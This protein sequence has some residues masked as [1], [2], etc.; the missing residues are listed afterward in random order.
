MKNIPVRS[1]APAGLVA[2]ALSGLFYLLG[3]C[4]N[5]NAVKPASSPLA[6]D[7]RVPVRTAPV[8]QKSIALPVHASGILSSSAEQRLS[9]KIGGVIQRILVEEGDVV[10]P[11]QLLAVLDKTEIDAQVTQAQ[12]GLSKAERDLARVQ[13]L[14]R[15]SS[16]TLELLENATTGRDV[17]KETARIAQFNRQY[18]EIRATRGGKIIKK[19]MNEGEI[20]GPGMPVL[21][22]FETGNDDWVVRINVSDRD[23]ARLNLGMIATVRMDAYPETIFNG[24]VSDLAPAADPAS[25]L[26]PVEIKVTPQG[27]RF[28]PGLFASVDI[29][30]PQ[31][32][33]YALVPVEAIVEGEGKSAWVFAIQA[34]GETVRKI[35][36]QV[37]FLDGPKVVIAGGLENVGEVITAGAPYLTEKSRVRL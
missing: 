9:F 11:G 10:R 1:I 16:A 5:S 17:A 20:T 3:G 22:L 31:A 36:V 13:G 7:E 26:Y 35:P 32:R 29:T 2:L 15:D 27:K 33:T 8:E 19:L 24:K 28:A 30:P 14:Y 18:A 23:W 4:G 6:A 34:D 21:V 25:G 12:Q 37:A